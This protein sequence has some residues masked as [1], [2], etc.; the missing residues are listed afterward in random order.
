M[1]PLTQFIID[2]FVLELPITTIREKAKAG[3]YAPV[4]TTTMK[5]YVDMSGRK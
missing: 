4:S 2:L 3:A 1:F 5:G